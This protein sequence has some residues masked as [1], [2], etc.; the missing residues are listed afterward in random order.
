[1]M[2][3]FV[4]QCQKKALK[5]TRRVL[6]A[7]ANRIGNRT[8]Q[9]VITNEG[10]QVVQK[11]LRKTASKNTAV[12]CHWIRSRN[13]SE[14]VWVVGNKD[15]FNFDGYVPV[16]YTQEEGLL[17]MDE[18]RWRN[19]EVISLLAAIAGLFH[20]FGKA[21]QL[22]QNKL[23]PLKKGKNY[24]P[25]RHEWVSLRLFEAFVR[26]YSS[27]LEND[28]EWLQALVDVNNSYEE[29]V[30]AKLIQD[31]EKT[32]K[33]VFSNLPPVAKL[34]AWLIVSHHR[35]PVYLQQGKMQPSYE[36][37]DQWLSRVESI[38]N[39]PNCNNQEWDKQTRRNNWT[40]PQGTPFVSAIWQI[41]ASDLAKRALSC[42][43]LLEKS[44][45]NQR[46]TAHL[47]RLSLMLADHY[48]SFQTKTT[49][50]WQD[51][52][53]TC[54][55]NTHH[56]GRYKQQLDEHN[57]GVAD[58]ARKFAKTLPQLRQNLP[59]MSANDT[60]TKSRYK[61]KAIK[62]LF[63]WQG[64]S[65]NLAKSLQ[66]STKECG[67]FG[68]NMASTGRGKTIAN[69]RIMYALSDEKLGCR[70]N[71]ALGLRTLTLQT[72]KALAKMLKLKEEDYAVLIGSQAVKQLDDLHNKS[73][74]QPSIESLEGSASAKDLFPEDQYIDYGGVLKN[75]HLSEWLKKGSERNPK[76][77][78]LIEAP[79][80]ISTID[81][82]M[83]ATEGTRG[84]KQIA[85]MLRLL[86]SDLVLD[87]PDDFNLEDLPALCRLVNW[88]A[89]LGGKVL[90]STATMPPI[91]SYALFQA[92]QA[93]WKD[94][95]AVN[96]EKGVIETICC[97]WFDE[98]DCS[99]TQS[100][101]T[102]AF[103]KLHDMF[104]EKR[105]NKLLTTS[106][107]LC[108]AR[109]LPIQTKKETTPI[110]QMADTIYSGIC[111]LHK[112]HHQSN[113]QGSSLSMGLVRMANINPLVAIAKHLLTLSPP[114]NTYIH[115]CIYHG[116]YPLLLRSSLENRLDSVLNRDNPEQI[117]QHPDI[118]PAL[119]Q[120]PNK[121]HVFVVIATSVAEVG[122]DHD[123]DWA[124]A[125]PSSMRSLIQL[126]GRIQ[127]HR[128]QEPKTENMLILSTNYK[129]LKGEKTAYLKP[130]FE[131]AKR[132]LVSHKIEEIL[133]QE[134]FQMINAI[135]R[136]VFYS[137][138]TLKNNEGKYLNLVQLEHMA[139]LECLITG[140]DDKNH[141][142]HWW[143]SQPTWSGELQRRQRFRCS[144]PDEIFCLSLEHEDE[145][146]KWMKKDETARPPIY[147]W[148]NEIKSVSDPQKASG[149]MI[150]FEMNIK[151][152]Y[153]KLSS[154][155]GK[156]LL[157]LS[158]QFAE[159]RLPKGLKK[160]QKYHPALGVFEEI[161]DK[162]I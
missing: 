141:A 6:D 152:L 114:E 134:Q 57:I 126:A 130:G 15:K 20:D 120:H 121:Q 137:D 106:K 119:Q 44:W 8:W 53:Y 24:E 136:I 99:S 19:T 40:F 146:L 158:Q 87:E 94:Y 41:Q 155:L 89:M 69:A 153:L 145:N 162:E 86:T 122:R 50:H 49:S 139:L 48:Y 154:Q 111:R 21:N 23:N 88:T 123:Y 93:G 124:I 129:A 151:E 38:W 149:N 62:A 46:F 42:P 108:K 78:Q 11:L 59:T 74:E 131:T 51:R 47:S 112:E 52:N 31:S 138:K 63:G 100:S 133:E 95:T 85:P 105:I 113:Q 84:G 90:L 65:Y 159:I 116:K 68:I 142:K 16:N 140:G 32:T 75:K 13:R 91:L 157:P 82:L 96:G 61:T 43:K 161:E 128:K 39:S 118:A 98:F 18:E 22:F 101:D 58:N 81:H 5:K 117:W 76:L 17:N 26:A 160:K 135:P 1:M 29:K 150:W 34:V 55:A 148:N 107:P 104:V 67:F 56:D 156:D 80:L 35:L 37:I 66:K 102:Q 127:R 2:V 97:A 25:Y 3:T 64:K 45:F 125:E 12:S 33:K 36:D 115:Y 30:L 60:I 147:V 72:G 70:F 27:N 54:Y 73:E 7:F 28:Q 83:P 4:S 77:Q 9:T 109:L 144:P 14:F 79:L 10:L 143:D 103:R 110:K 132:S 92:Y 71:I